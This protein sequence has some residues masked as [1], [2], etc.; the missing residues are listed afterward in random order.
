MVYSSSYRIILSANYLNRS[1]F[2]ISMEDPKIIEEIFKNADHVFRYVGAKVLL[3]E[4]G[5]A[6]VEIPFKEELTRRGNVLHGGIIM[7]AID[8]TGGLA[9]FTVNDGVDQVTQELKV[10]FLQPMY[11]G[12]FRVEGKVLRKGS[13]VIVV[14]IEFRD[15]EGNLGAKALGSWYI[16]R[17][18]VQGAL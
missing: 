10:N 6:V 13:T 3:L 2:F 5:R 12:P 9:A 7:T 1:P 16:L 17:K 11:K 8:F 18:K 4:Q 15:A 14:E